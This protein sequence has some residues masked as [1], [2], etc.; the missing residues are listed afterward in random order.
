MAM[1]C[2]SHNPRV[3]WWN[4]N[5]GL[6]SRVNFHNWLRPGLKLH[7]SWPKSTDR[8][9]CPNRSS[10]HFNAYVQKESALFKVTVTVVIVLFCRFP[11]YPLCCLFS[12]T[13]GLVGRTPKAQASSPRQVPVCSPYAASTSPAAWVL[14]VP[15]RCSPV[16]ERGRLKLAEI[17]I[18]WCEG[19]VQCGVRVALG[20]WMLIQCLKKVLS[21]CWI[22]GILLFFQLSDS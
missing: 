14:G 22:L 9:W 19:I 17:C 8:N 11:T 21:S 7:G 6:W 4:H 15:R 12:M 5:S 20:I 2:H 3:L 18:C 16:S 13:R 1:W 10:K